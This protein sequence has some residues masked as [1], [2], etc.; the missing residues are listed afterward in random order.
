MGGYYNVSGVG[1]GDMRTYNTSVV[2]AGDNGAIGS[3]HYPG[4]IYVY[5]PTDD[6]YFEQS[7][8]L[9]V[10]G[11]INGML[12]ANKWLMYNGIWYDF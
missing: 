9:N 3:Y 4:Y 10:G 11:T 6:A 8:Y 2:Y 1:F 7:M 5:T 12:L